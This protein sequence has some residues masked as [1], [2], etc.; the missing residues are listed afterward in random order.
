MWSY[1]P[2]PRVGGSRRTLALWLLNSSLNLAFREQG[3]G[4]CKTPAAL[5]VPNKTASTSP[6]HRPALEGGPAVG[7]WLCV[8][9]GVAVTV[10][11]CPWLLTRT[12][13]D[14]LLNWLSAGEAWL[15]GVCCFVCRM[16]PCGTCMGR[17]A[18]GERCAPK[19]PFSA[20]VPQFCSAPTPRRGAQLSFP[21][22]CSELSAKTGHKR[23]EIGAG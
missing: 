21:A 16:I 22:V 8:G 10:T 15:V 5:P 12:E 1:H 13:E 23:S 3:E 11:G 9:V 4:G 17:E 18:E 19:P 14:W 20:G 6:W 7:A 2:E